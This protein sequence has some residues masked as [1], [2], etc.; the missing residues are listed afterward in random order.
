MQEGGIMAYNKHRN[1]LSSYD[2]RQWRLWCLVMVGNNAHKTDT[3]QTGVFVCKL[4]RGITQ[5]EVS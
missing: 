2:D 4:I 5:E 3:I 1:L